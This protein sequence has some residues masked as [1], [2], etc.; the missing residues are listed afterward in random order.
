MSIE[1]KVWL[2]RKCY[3]ITTEFG[4]F[5]G[6][7]FALFKLSFFEFVDDGLITIVSLQISKLNIGLHAIE[8][9]E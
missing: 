5:S 8:V 2:R 1:L 4:W 9:K 7:D 3:A 6:N